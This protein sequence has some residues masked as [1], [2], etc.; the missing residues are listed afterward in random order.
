ME[1]S[2]LKDAEFAWE[3]IGGITQKLMV[4]FLAAKEN[5]YGQSETKVKQRD[6]RGGKEDASKRCVRL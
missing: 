1:S 3:R 4:E 5:Q 6:G 2:D